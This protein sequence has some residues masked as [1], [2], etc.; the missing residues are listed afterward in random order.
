MKTFKDSTY[1]RETSLDDIQTLLF[2][3]QIIREDKQQ[4]IWTISDRAALWNDLKA[5]KSYLNNDFEKSHIYIAYYGEIKLGFFGAINISEIDTNAH[6]V[7]WIDNSVRKKTLFVKWWIFF[8]L[9]LQKK[10]IHRLCARIKKKNNTS[11]NAAK[12]FGFFECKDVS[13]CL[14]EVYFVTRMSEL[15]PFEK[16]YGSS[17]NCVGS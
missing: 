12:R 4:Y 14:N 9:E 2:L 8:L 10:G 16:K 6:L 7:V 1:I 11:I 3:K 15:N 17:G 5:L 13:K